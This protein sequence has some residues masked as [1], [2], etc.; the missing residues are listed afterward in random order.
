MSRFSTFLL[1]NLLMLPFG[2]YAEESQF[3]EGK[4]YVRFPE[5]LPVASGK[6]EVLEFFSYGCPHCKDFEPY[7]QG[8][9]KKLPAS[10]EARQ[11]PSVMNKSGEM[12]AKIFYAAEDLGV[13]DKVHAA[14]FNAVQVERNPMQTEEQVSAFVKNLGID[15]RKFLDAMKSFDIDSR[16]RKAM[17]VMRAYR[18]SGVPSVAVNGRYLSGGGMVGNFA[19][20]IKVLDYLVAKEIQVVKTEGAATKNKAV[21]I[22]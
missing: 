15:E 12:H 20:L 22:N 4:H 16:V 17:Q 14:L 2:S 3:Q 11:V 19:E 18:I 10:V 6:I 13:H 1:L 21:S 7:F 5:Q 9:K 8:W